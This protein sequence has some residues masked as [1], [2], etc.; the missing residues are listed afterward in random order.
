MDAPDYRRSAN[1]TGGAGTQLRR[2]IILDTQAESDWM[3]DGTGAKKRTGEVTK[4][5]CAAH[6]SRLRRLI[7]HRHLVELL[8]L[9]RSEGKFFAI[10]EGNFRP[11]V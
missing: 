5:F 10:S 3:S 2:G 4:P 6:I 8:L 9:N 7:R 11:G 1:G